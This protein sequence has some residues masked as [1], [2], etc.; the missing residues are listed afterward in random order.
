MSGAARI[1][2][3]ESQ[4]HHHYADGRNGNRKPE[5]H[6]TATQMDAEHGAGI[7]INIGANS[8]RDRYREQRD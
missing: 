4:I 1:L 3:P 5:T 7:N 2:S 6:G 8:D